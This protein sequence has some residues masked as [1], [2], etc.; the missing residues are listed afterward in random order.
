MPPLFSYLQQ[1]GAVSTDEMRDVF[2]LGIG[3]I[4]VLPQEA[5]PAVRAAAEHAG[6]EAWR[7]GHVE[8]GVP[9]VRFAD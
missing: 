1:A 3:M 4:A 5:E 6:V 8:S 2:N 7:I 9:S